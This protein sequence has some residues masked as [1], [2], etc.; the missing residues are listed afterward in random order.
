MKIISKIESYYPSLTKSEKKVA[1]YICD[2]KG[3]ILNKT[4]SDISSEIDVGEATILRFCSKMGYDKFNE[5]KFEIARDQQEETKEQETDASDVVEAAAMDFRVMVDK[6]KD[7]IDYAQLKKA[8]SILEK[9][10]KI[11]IFG[12]GASG[13]SALA[14]QNNLLRLGIVSLAVTDSHF[15]AMESSILNRK[16]AV[17]A[18]S[19]TGNTKDIYDACMIAKNNKASIIAVTSYMDSSLARI[20]DCVLLTAVRENLIVGGTLCGNVSQFLVIDALKSEYTN[21]HKSEVKK[22]REETAESILPKAL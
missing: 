15:Q 6:T 20:A 2:R 17:L 22:T 4:L 10:D 11:L 9:A 8:V 18:F 14:A 5:L 7:T 16:S 19:L 3:D 21:R 12:V 1:Q 13:F